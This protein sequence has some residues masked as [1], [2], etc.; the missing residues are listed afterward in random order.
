[1][2]TGSPGAQTQSARNAAHNAAH[3][4]AL[5]CR[6]TETALSGKAGSHSWVTKAISRFLGSKIFSLLS[7]I[8]SPLCSGAVLFRA[9]RKFPADVYV[10]RGVMSRRWLLTSVVTSYFL[11]ACQVNFTPNCKSEDV[12]Y[13][14]YRS[15]KNK[16]FILELAESG[17]GRIEV[18]HKGNRYDIDTSWGFDSDSRELFLEIDARLCEAIE[19]LLSW[20]RPEKC[21]EKRNYTKWVAAECPVFGPVRLKLDFDSGDHLI[22]V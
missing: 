13:G 14:E 11:T 5:L 19:N 1:M 18:D 6:L 9:R 3:N 22:K 7:N 2:S 20:P 10:D 16:T 4:A 12:L 17:E 8:R 21:L 15:I